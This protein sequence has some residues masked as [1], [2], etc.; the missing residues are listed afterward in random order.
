[1]IAE[2]K[3]ESFETAAD[4]FSPCLKLTPP[5]SQRT[6]AGNIADLGIFFLVFE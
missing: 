1:M 3:L 4:V 5:S 6:I 2:L